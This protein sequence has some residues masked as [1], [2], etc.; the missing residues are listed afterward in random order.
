MT[1]YDDMAECA[2]DML[3]EFGADAVIQRKTLATATTAAGS[4]EITTPNATT[5]TPAPWEVPETAT[6]EYPCKAVVSNYHESVLNGSAI[7]QGDKKIIVAASGLT[8]EPAVT[9]V[10]VCSGIAY[11]IVSVTVVSPAGTPI[12]YV[13]QAR[14]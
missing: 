7:K 5:S 11:N 12:I 3:V 14:L 9:D 2:L 10:I 6:L 1:L 13:V 4:T 8:I